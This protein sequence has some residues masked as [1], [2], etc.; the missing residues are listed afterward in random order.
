MYHRNRF[1]RP[2]PVICI[3]V[4]MPGC[5]ISPPHR[6]DNG[7]CDYLAR[8]FLRSFGTV[9]LSTW[10]G[11]MPLS[12]CLVRA[13]C[14]MCIWCAQKKLRTLNCHAGPQSPGQ[15]TTTPLAVAAGAYH[16]L[17]HTKTKVAY[18]YEAVTRGSCSRIK[19]CVS[20]FMPS[21]SSGDD[22]MNPGCSF[23]HDGHVPLHGCE[24]PVWAD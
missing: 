20:A 15:S 2:G 14:W 17:P 11:I 5:E 1:E 22:V 13:A 3:V 6:I 19:R 23:H 7:R 24:R 12:V 21:V 8:S 10:L 18:E 9:M 4:G 16:L